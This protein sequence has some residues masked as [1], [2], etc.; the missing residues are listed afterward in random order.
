MVSYPQPPMSTHLRPTQPVAA[1]GLLPGDPGRALALA[2]DLLAAPLMANHHRGL[3]G[4]HGR[5]TDDRALTVQATGVGGPSAAIVL[6]ELA[7]L[8]LRRA[9][10]I[11][12][13]RTVVGRGLSPG[14]VAVVTEAVARDGTSRSLGATGAVE[15]SPGLTK[16]LLAAAPEAVPARVETHDLYYPADLRDEYCE[17][18]VAVEMCAAPLFALGRSLGLEL[19]CLLV[20]TG[21]T[22]G[23]G[24]TGGEKERLAAVSD[25]ALAESE[26]Q[27][28]RIAVAA[29]AGSA[30]DDVGR[31]QSFSTS[32][33]D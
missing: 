11:G 33:P 5:T 12:T 3:W 17:G 19:G 2:Q 1:D 10:R 27:M 15:P 9:V 6:R 25:T 4:Y 23:A 30:A 22:T 14:L 28:G 16:A 26:L 24:S 21:A 8:G 31:A 32:S 20:A 29:L 7:D 18:S 13:C